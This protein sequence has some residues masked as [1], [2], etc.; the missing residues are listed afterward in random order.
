MNSSSVSG[1]GDGLEEFDVQPTFVWITEEG[2]KTIHHRTSPRHDEYNIPI[3]QVNAQ[4]W[5]FYS[6]VKKR[7]GSDE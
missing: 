6:D 2:G 4:I 3:R 7:L 5:S 1:K